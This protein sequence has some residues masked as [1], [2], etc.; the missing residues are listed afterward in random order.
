MSNSQQIT[1][2]LRESLIALAVLTLLAVPGDTRAQ[3]EIYSDGLQWVGSETVSPLSGPIYFEIH[4][5]MLYGSALDGTT[6]TF[7]VTDLSDPDNPLPLGQVAVAGVTWET[8]YDLAADH[9]YF[10]Y[11][12]KFGIIDVSNPSSPSQ[13]A[14]ISSPTISKDVEVGLPYAYFA[15]DGATGGVQIYDVSDPTNPVHV[16]DSP[17]FAAQQVALIDTYLYYTANSSFHLGVLDVTN[18][19]SPA[20]AWDEVGQ[21]F[22][23]LAVEDD[24]LMVGVRDFGVRIYDIS[25][26]TAPVLVGSLETPFFPSRIMLREGT[27]FLE[28]IAHD[29]YGSA[30]AVLDY[31]DPTSPQI[32]GVAENDLVAFDLL[33][34]EIWTSDGSAVLSRFGGAEFTNPQPLGPPITL[35]LPT[36]AVDVAGDY[37]YVGTAFFSGFT[38]VD[39]S[40]PANL[41]VAGAYESGRVVD[42][43]VQND[44]AYVSDEAGFFIVDVS[45][46]SNP[47]ELSE[48]DDG[49]RRRHIVVDGNLAYV[50]SGNGG[51]QIYDVSDPTSPSLLGFDFL[52]IQDVAVD[53]E[54]LIVLGNQLIVYDVSDPTNPTQ[55]ASTSFTG[56]ASNIIWH[57]TTAYAT[58][59]V[60]L[61]TFDLS[62]PGTPVWLGRTRL[63]DAGT[64]MAIS[65]DR[66]YVAVTSGGVHVYDL[67]DP[68]A[69]T[70]LGFAHPGG[71]CIDL[72]LSAD[73]DDLFTIAADIGLFA[74][75]VDC[76]PTTSAPD[77]SA[78]TDPL[79]GHNL[80]LTPNPT[81][82]GT[83]I[84]WRVSDS[85]SV[86]ASIFDAQGRRVWKETRQ[87]AGGQVRF[88]WDGLG[89]DG[90]PRSSGVYYVRLDGEEAEAVSRIHLV[91]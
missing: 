85:Q 73:G 77:E 88:H 60:F 58:G 36:V 70:L 30:V 71:S 62:D 75:P 55:T 3:C 78:D 21:P 39:A 50:V 89:Q 38:I 29:G 47:V 13:V 1:G 43:E 84:Q 4:D 19:A 46:P 67:T 11:N 82:S 83:H 7:I 34:D 33:G 49:I 86:Q 28:S 14:E 61:H 6:R 53:G 64:R 25:T 54:Q 72:D 80:R 17:D 51:F 87:A 59:S 32:V 66:L 5:E 65:A 44:I 16:A 27:A 8:T 40:D 45:D 41:F 31:S 74:F 2:P 35:D 15:S 68:M 76:G 91:R 90:A 37:V 56:T 24:L 20:V 57:G 18:P 26:R 23:S 52:P 79:S 48:V 9:V 22:V 10:A 42:L 69:P 81:S 63:L 12:N